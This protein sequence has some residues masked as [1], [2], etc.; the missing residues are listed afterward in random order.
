MSIFSSDFKLGLLGGG[1]LGRMLLQAAIDLDVHVKCLD[2]DPEAPCH[3]IA[4]EFI[5]GSFQDFDTV[6]A[7][8]QDCQVITI[9]IENVNLEALEKLQAEGKKV[10]P[11]PEVIRIIQDKRIQKQFYLDNNLPTAD[12]VLTDSIEDIRKNIGFLPAFNKLGKGGYDGKGVQ[13][14]TTEADLSLA[15][16][17]PSL[18]EKAI[19]FEKEIAI[20]TARN[21]QGE[22]K[23]F[24]T[25]EMVFNPVHNLVE[26]LFAPA[27]ISEDILKQAQE[28]ARNV[29]EKLGI[30]GLLAVEMFVTQDGKVLINEVAP[31]THNSGHHTI[32]ANHT[33]QFEQHLRA[34]LSL[35]LG[36]TTAHSKAAMVNLLGEDGYSGES[37]YVGMKETLAIEGVYPFL[38]GKKTTKPFRKMG[39]ITLV[40]NNLETLKQ[41]VSQV[42]HLLKV[43]S[44]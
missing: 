7:F 13:K 28:I 34:V 42:Q 17:Q 2:P 8:G 3:K 38:Y 6:Y 26:Y 39:H 20:I 15:F 30:V 9:E 14:L 35:P 25:V 21:E 33:S 23:L 24:P 37:K 18:L 5:Q 19:D 44:E 32:R 40:D 11:Q 4:S 10:F 36:D 31:R 41:K 12:F 43:I 22:V 1:Q 16:T 27:E 29:T